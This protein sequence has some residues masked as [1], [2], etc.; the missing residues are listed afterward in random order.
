MSRIRV[1]DGLVVGE[2]Y[3]VVFDAGLL[4]PRQMVATFLGE[5]EQAADFDL[6]PLAGTQIIRKQDVRE[7][8]ETDLP[9]MLPRIY[10]G[11][12]RVL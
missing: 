6:R 10:R 8:Y 12:T 4:K 2:R 7:I 5:S 3:R 1:G 9:L 11:E